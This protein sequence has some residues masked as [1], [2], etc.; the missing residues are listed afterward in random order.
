[1][2]YVDAES[3]T[4]VTSNARIGGKFHVS[5]SLELQTSNQHIDTEVFLDHDAITQGNA[6]TNLTLHTSNA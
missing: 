6:S 3:A 2:Q 1:M 4:I 5:R